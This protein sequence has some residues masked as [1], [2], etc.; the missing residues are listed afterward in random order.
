[1][2]VAVGLTV[3][4]APRGQR[5]L[6]AAAVAV[7]EAVAW[8]VILAAQGVGLLEAYTLP[9]ALL[10]L[11][12]GWYAARAR[13]DLSSW[14]FA[15]PA[16]AAALLPSLAGALTEESGTPL[17]RLL[18]GLGA[19]AITVFGSMRRLQAPVVLGGGTLLVLALHELLLVS[20]LLPTW[21]PI[22]VG[23]AVLLALAITYERSRRD[24]ARLR[25]PSAGCGNHLPMWRSYRKNG[26]SATLGGRWT[27]GTSSG[28]C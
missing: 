24:V 20:R 3:L 21:V 5:V 1:M 7:V 12:V 4:A 17:R 26:E 27:S 9:V 11:A 8:C 23:G 2:G 6:R 18:L 19:L 25:G 28:C 16:L 22:A 13:P 14:L 10:A 15:G